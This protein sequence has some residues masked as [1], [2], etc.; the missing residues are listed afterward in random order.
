MTFFAVATPKEGEEIRR[1]IGR[2]GKQA[3]ILIPGY[4]PPAKAARLARPGLTQALPSLACAKERNRFVERAGVRIFCH[5][6]RRKAIDCEA[7][8]LLSFRVERIYIKSR[9]K[10]TRS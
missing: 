1:Q 4:P 6:A 3:E 8:C 7:L 9:R 5:V 2:L 10:P